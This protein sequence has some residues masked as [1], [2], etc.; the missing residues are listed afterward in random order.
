MPRE[1]APG[2]L[3]V[4]PGPTK[5]RQGGPT[6]ARDAVPSATEHAQP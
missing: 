4:P 2:D 6:W 1:T 5:A 3:R